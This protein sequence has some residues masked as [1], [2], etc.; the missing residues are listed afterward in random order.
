[1]PCR[2]EEVLMTRRILV[3]QDYPGQPSYL[4]LLFV[5]A[6]MILIEIIIVALRDIP[7]WAKIALVVV[8]ALAQLGL[9]IAGFRH[10][11]AA[12]RR[13]FMG[14]AAAVIIAIAAILIA[15]VVL[16]DDDEVLPVDAELTEETDEPEDQPPVD[17]EAPAEEDGDEA[18]GDEADEE[19]DTPADDEAAAAADSGEVTVTMSTFAIDLSAS[20]APAGEVTFRVA[21]E[22]SD[23]PHSLAVVRSD[24]PADQLPTTETGDPDEAQLDIVGQTEPIEPGDTAEL[25]LDLE[26]GQYVLVDLIPNRYNEGMFAEFTVLGEE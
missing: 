3:D 5:L 20:A 23:L 11:S 12:N 21:N 6:A 1:M 19:G 4:G 7:D 24:Q 8:L 16:T 17:E 26:P 10:M 9:A 15:A 22:A 13:I 2:N 25:T 14:G 18:E